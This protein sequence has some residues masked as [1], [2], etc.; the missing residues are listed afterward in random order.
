MQAVTLYKLTDK[1][2]RTYNGMQWGEGVTHTASG[3]GELCG[4]GWIH[5]Y[6]DPLLAVLL[7]PI[8]AGFGPTAHLWEAEG[9]IGTTHHGLKVGC[10]SLTTLRRVGLPALTTEQRVRFAI[11]CAREVYTDPAWTAWA[12][13]WLSGENRMR[14]AAAA[15]EEEVAVATWAARE[16]GREAAVAAAWAVRGSRAAAEVAVEA[17]VAAAAW[18]AGAVEAA[19]EAGLDLPALAR[20]AVTEERGGQRDE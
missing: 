20:R 12:D 16:T 4:P 13:C 2:D 3:T 14:A 15:A 8:Y 6:T 7:D 10:T 18:A 19:A 1:D 11:L 17:E 5:A 9:V